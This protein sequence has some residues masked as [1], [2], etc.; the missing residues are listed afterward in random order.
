MKAFKEI[1]AYELEN[2]M[3]LIGKDWMLLTA[4]DTKN[5]RVNAMTASWGMMGVLWN[6]CVCT[7]F[8]RPQ[9]HTYSLIDAGE[10]FSIAFMDEKHRGALAL[11]GKESGRDCDKLA[12][13]GLTTAS[14]DGV[15]Y[16]KEA[17][18]VLVCRKLYADDLKENAFLDKSL[19]SNYA[20]GDYHRAY[21][22][23][24]EKAYVRE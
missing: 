19:L 20:A 2:A 1:S 14:T 5:Q 9:R 16:I 21:I 10:R 4:E 23:E 8:V 22:C 18:I 6:K 11:C 7:V 24:I 15:A 17:R 3:K 12:K 13:A